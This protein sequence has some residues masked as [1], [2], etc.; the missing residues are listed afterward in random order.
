MRAASFL[1]SPFSSSE[2]RCRQSW[3]RQ[4]FVR[5]IKMQR[6]EQPEEAV[7]DRAKEPKLVR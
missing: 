1:A 5:H 4:Q 6:F 3:C 2:C 7:N